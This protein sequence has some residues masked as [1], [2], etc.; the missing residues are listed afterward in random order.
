MPL[1]QSCSPCDD[2]SVSTGVTG[3]EPIG[4]TG[5]GGSIVCSG[6]VD[7]CREVCHSKERAS[8]FD[9][10]ACLF[11]KILVRGAMLVERL[12]LQNLGLFCWKIGC[13]VANFAA[14]YAYFDVACSVISKKHP[15]YTE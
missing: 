10:F 3:V 13:Q 4:S 1:C 11:S 12:C 2:L 7:E 8:L 6:C 5:L 9:C 14:V 15:Q